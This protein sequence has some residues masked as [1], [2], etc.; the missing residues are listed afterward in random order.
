[1]LKEYKMNEI[2]TASNYDKYDIG[3]KAERLFIMKSKGINVPELICVKNVCDVCSRIDEYFPN[4]R[5]FS[6]RSSSVCEDSSAYS[7]AGQFETFLNV[8]PCDINHYVKQCIESFECRRVRNYCDVSGMT[9]KK[10]EVTAIIQE[11]ITAE[12]SGVIF[13][14]NPQGIL[15]ETVIAVGRGTG[16][17]VVEDKTDITLYYYNLSDD[18]F[19]YETQG[20]SPLLSNTL[21]SGLIGVSKKITEIFGGSQDIEFA[22]KNDEI[23]ILQARPITTLKTSMP[24]VLDSSNISESYPG[25]CLP[26]TISFVGEVYYLVFSSCIRRLTKNDG[27]AERLDGVLHNMVDSANGRIYYRIS[28]WYDVI[29]LLPFSKKIIP[30][31]QEMLGVKDKSVSLSAKSAGALT[32]LKV[33][34]SFFQLIFTNKRKMKKLDEYFRKVYADC[35]KEL[36]SAEKPSELFDIYKKLKNAL[37]SEWDLTLVNDMYTFI[38]TGLLKARLKR[39]F[40][41]DYRE[42]T[43]RCISGNAEIESLKPLKLLYDIKGSLAEEDKLSVLSDKVEFAKLINESDSKSALL[44]NEYISLYGDRSPDELKLEAET[45][46]TDT[47]IIADKIINAEAPVSAHSAEKPVL[48]GINKKIAECAS[49]GI[50]LREQSRMSRGRIFGLVRSIILKIAEKFAEQG[51]IGNTRDIFYLTFEELTEA[52]RNEKLS[53]DNIPKSRR[54]NFEVFEK[55]PPY[56]RLIFADEVFDKMPLNV[57]SDIMIGED[58]LKGIPCSSGIV[59]GK[60]MLVDKITSDMNAEGK[61]IVAKMTD[62]GWVFLINQSLGII[63]EKGSLLS[64]TAIVSRELGKPAVVGAANVFSRLKNGDTVRLNGSTGEITIV[65]EYK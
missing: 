58:T 57:N 37:A 28:G 13:T 64:H 39:K 55:L 24:V 52:V 23:Y 34:I 36:E 3:A 4:K 30:V 32:K 35:K 16:N 1:M 8:S 56:S 40:P 19:Y 50:M 33:T 53:I 63:S 42:I 61:I 49:E 48:K 20:D 10:T 51:R 2:I 59:V 38:F 12:L 62:P 17:N 15:N 26:M 25:I 29:N 22:V 54:H 7:F 46:R 9:D 21:I 6:V 43:N 60:V 14:A 11:M 44:I 31:W 5:L 47:G 18:V 41:E 65:E 45:C 27:T